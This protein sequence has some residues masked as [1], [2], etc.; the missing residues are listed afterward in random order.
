MTGIV[1]KLEDSR[2]AKNVSFFFTM[3][4]GQRLKKKNQPTS[5]LRGLIIVETGGRHRPR[6][7][8]S[9]TIV[10]DRTTKLSCL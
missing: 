4:S 8:K 5:V 7:R 9:V 10:T 3:P 6:G 1:L 2:D